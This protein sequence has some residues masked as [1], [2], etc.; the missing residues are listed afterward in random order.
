MEES[1]QHLYKPSLFRESIFVLAREWHERYESINIRLNLHSLTLWFLH[2]A[3][4]YVTSMLLFF[5]GQ[6]LVRS[7]IFSP[8]HSVYCRSIESMSWTRWYRTQWITRGVMVKKW[9]LHVF[10]SMAQITT[11][12]LI[13]SF[14]IWTAIL[15]IHTQYNSTFHIVSGLIIVAFGSV[16]AGS[17]RFFDEFFTAFVHLSEYRIVWR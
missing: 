10:F 3:H 1:V 15:H 16:D 4:Y 6:W 2:C 17:E 13:Q 12:S 5:F 7:A 9:Y 14:I 8:P 11:V